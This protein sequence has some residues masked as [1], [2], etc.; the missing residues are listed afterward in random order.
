MG[1]ILG[2]HYFV[3]IWQLLVVSV[4]IRTSKHSLGM[5]F[6]YNSLVCVGLEERW[7]RFMEMYSAG[8][9]HYGVL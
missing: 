9:G 3:V 1:R 5:R 8:E 7:L 4:C 6:V 2:S